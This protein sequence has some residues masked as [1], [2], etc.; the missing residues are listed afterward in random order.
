M[1]RV[2]PS[3][4]NDDETLGIDGLSINTTDTYR[5]D[6]ERFRPTHDTVPNAPDPGALEVRPL[7]TAPERLAAL[8]QRW[9][10][11]REPGQAEW[12]GI[13]NIAQMY[14]AVGIDAS[15]RFTPE[16]VNQK[17]NDILLE[18][19]EIQAEMYRTGQL[20][21]NNN[22]TMI[23]LIL[24]KLAAA[25][26]LLLGTCMLCQSDT[27]QP[28]DLP[29]DEYGFWRFLPPE[30]EGETTPLIRL[31]IFILNDA[32]RMG[33]RKYRNNFMCRIESHSPDGTVLPTCA[34]KAVYTFEE[35]VQKLTKR[36]LTNQ[37]VW[38]DINS[39]TGISNAESICKWLQF[40]HDVEIPWLEPDRHV[41]S[42]RNGVFLAKDEKFILYENMHL[43]YAGN[44]YPV[45]CKHFDMVFNPMWLTVTD[46]RNI[47]TPAMEEVFDTQHLS[48]DVRRWT[49]ALLGRLLYNVHELD[50]WQVFPFL[51]GLA[52]TGKSSIL[53]F[54]RMI[55][56]RHDVGTISNMIET[57]FGLGQ[58]AGKFIAIA[59]D[60]R[61][62]FR[63]DQ[64]D[65]QNMASGNATLVAVK[66]KDPFVV[67]PWTTPVLYSG[68]ES[69]G[70]HDNS[71]SYGRRMAV[72]AF[73]Y[74]VTRPDGSLPQRLADEMGA[75]IAKANMQYR[76]MIRRHG[77][78]GI[79]TI[80]PEEFKIQR[81]ELTAASNALI[82]LF[83][84]GLITKGA[85]L[86]MPLKSLRDACMMHAQRN[87][88]QRPQW[89]GEY[90][91]G[92]ITSEGL[93]ISPKTQ[94][95]KY[96]R[97]LDDRVVDFYVYG[98]DLTSNCDVSNPSRALNAQVQP[99]AP[100]PPIM[101]DSVSPPPARKRP[102]PPGGDQMIGH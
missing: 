90:Y 69:P 93:L 8:W 1:D 102:R 45:A 48:P 63:M 12:R 72:I 88:L 76:N 5:A 41:F 57:Q 86:Y 6:E 9:F 101:D 23:R 46:P 27:M 64:S 61:S 59:D 97:H 95:K 67:E 42:F 15:Q 21:V 13:F 28:S 29:R 39:G 2:P 100:P 70:F 91:R 26:Q 11:G 85:N 37:D 30:A 60:V 19:G 33:Y 18:V 71:G 16:T 96:P 35:Y 74:T 84:S 25:K 65:F 7:A 4:I 53:N 99:P 20:E 83:A 56:E 77:Q 52:G 58:I 40:S 32:L 36:R 14:D 24:Q 17:Y 10:S 89:G 49:Y 92:P 50:D 47:P 43:F 54:I 80:L 87:G 34:W 31:K 81:A 44:Q 66:N 79:W 62:S 55:Y 73:L 78:R 82:G 22:D 51:K 98:C 38:L 94:R 3:V 68:N 75:F